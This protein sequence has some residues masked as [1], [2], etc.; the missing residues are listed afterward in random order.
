MAAVATADVGARTEL[1][2]RDDDIRKMLV[3]KT[4]LGTKNADHKM[5]RYVVKRTTEGIHLINLSKTWEKLMLAARM[6]VA[7]ENPADVVV[8]A[9]RPYGSRAVLKFSQYTGAQAIAGR[10]TPGTLT[11]QITQKFMEPR[12]VIATDPRLDHQ[13]IKE[14]AYANIPVIALCDTD[15]PLEYVDV[16]VPC[17]NRGKESIALMYW[18]LARE[19]L[20]LRGRLNRGQAWEVMP[21]M[22]FW[23]DPAEFE[24][25]QGEAALVDVGPQDAVDATQGDWA[26]VATT[27]ENAAAQEWGTVSATGAND[28]WSNVV[29]APAAATANAAAGGAQSWAPAQGDGKW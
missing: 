27:N 11:N 21:D 18:M 9:A 25:K 5:T 3:C 26:A 23:R 19:I 8:V 13:A 14:C 2:Q 24:A 7:I 17:N 6:V 1:P 22:F 20:C 10:W 4:Y 16:A 12:L 29:P 15:S 28:Q